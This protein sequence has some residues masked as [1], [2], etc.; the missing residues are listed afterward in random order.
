MP[1]GES[2]VAGRACELV[3]WL[4][5][6][7]PNHSAVGPSPGMP[8]VTGYASRHRVWVCP[9]TLFQN[10]CNCKGLMSA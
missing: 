3:S 2:V 9:V 4:P 6:W 5:L 8:V 10:R 1:W 7:G